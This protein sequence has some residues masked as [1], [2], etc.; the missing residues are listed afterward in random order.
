M[1]TLKLKITEVSKYGHIIFFLIPCGLHVLVNTI[2]FI[3]TAIYSSRVKAEIHRMQ[4]ASND[5]SQMRRIR[6]VADKEMF[7]RTRRLLNSERF[8][9]SFIPLFAVSS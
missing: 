3:L 2:L 4:S 7:V 1:F 8:S 6:F 5:D 9:K